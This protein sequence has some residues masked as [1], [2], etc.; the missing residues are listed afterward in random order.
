M[1]LWVLKALLW[2]LLGLVTLLL[3]AVLGVLF[4]PVTYT[5]RLEARIRPDEESE[6]GYS[7][8]TRWKAAARWGQFLVRYQVEGE[9]ATITH[10][11]LRILG[12]PVG[13]RRK[14]ADA[15]KKAADAEK[16]AR[17]KK[18]SGF[19]W[20][21]VRQYVREGSA[22]LA[23]IWDALHLHL[24]GNLVFGFADPADTGLTL[25]FLWMVGVPRYMR[26][27]PDFVYPHLEGELDFRGRIWGYQLAAALWIA[28]WNLPIGPHRWLRFKE[29]FTRKPTKYVGG[30]A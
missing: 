2:S 30:R 17:R 25:G 19:S 28:F 8:Q 3:L 20:D 26:V 6:L 24:D 22:L 29:W 11:R 15:G 18:K 27:Q 23:R 9:D 21:M 14:A 10:Q 5:G 12:I 16:K 7:G 4:V 13:R 1:L